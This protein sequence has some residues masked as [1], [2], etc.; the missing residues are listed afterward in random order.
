MVIDSCFEATTKEPIALHYLR[1]IGVDPATAV[2]I[3]IISHW[4]DD[5][6]GGAARMI[7]ACES[8]KV[9]Y[10]IALLKKEFITLYQT[11]ASPISLVDRY[12]SGVREMASVVEILNHRAR[13]SPRNKAEVLQPVIADRLLF[14]NPRAAANEVKVWALSPSSGSVQ[15]AL[16]QIG[17]LIPTKGDD[18]TVVSRSSQNHNAVVIWIQ[19]GERAILLGSDLLETGD[20]DTGWSAIVNSKLRPQA[21]AN[22]FKIPHHG[23]HTGHCHEVWTDMIET[24]SHAILT[25]FTRGQSLPTKKDIHRLKGYTPNIYCTLEPKS[26]VPK[27]HTAVEKTIKGMVKGR[28]V[29]GGEM[30]QIQVRMKGNSEIRLALKPPAVT[31]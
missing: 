6:T 9:F 31:L 14:Q 15:K 10:S 3:I 16:M 1:K 27:R 19:F 28:K 13:L 8:A 7:A 2:K 20:P 17:S 25:T 29:L 5:H 21:K 24:G 26:K 18:R 30:G 22:I 23:S 4:H 12:T 11:L